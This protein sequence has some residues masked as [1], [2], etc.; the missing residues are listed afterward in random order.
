MD[1]RL[2]FRT[3]EG[4]PVFGMLVAADNKRSDEREER[5]TQASAIIPGTIF[6]FLLAAL[7]I[8][9]MSP[10]HLPA[11]EEQPRPAGHPGGDHRIADDDVGHHPGRRPALRR[12]HRRGADREQRGHG[13]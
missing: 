12:H 13:A 3:L 11:P 9:V 10:R 7:F 1:F 2:T 4:K 8:T 5:L 6:W